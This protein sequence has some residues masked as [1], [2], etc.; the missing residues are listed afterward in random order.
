MGMD[1]E[2]LSVPA[3][4]RVVSGLRVPLSLGGE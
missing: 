1:L 2:G 4:R 3:E